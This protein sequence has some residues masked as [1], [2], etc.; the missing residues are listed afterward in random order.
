MRES[1]SIAIVS[2]NFRGGKYAP[3]KIRPEDR[4][5]LFRDL[6]KLAFGRKLAQALH[7]RTGRDLSTCKRWLSERHEPSNDAF[8]AVIEEIIRR[9]RRRQPRRRS[10]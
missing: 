9:Y 2:S 6:A 7:E 5:I 4:G 8:T 3:K 1:D 10:A